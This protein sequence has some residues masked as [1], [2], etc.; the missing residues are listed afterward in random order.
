[1]QRNIYH[2]SPLKLAQFCLAHLRLNAE[3]MPENLLT[4]LA[5]V[6][7]FGVRVSYQFSDVFAS[8]TER[9]LS[10]IWC[11]VLNEIWT[12]TLTLQVTS[13]LASSS[14]QSYLP[15]PHSLFST[16]SLQRSHIRL[17]RRPIYLVSRHHDFSIPE[18]AQVYPI[19]V[20]CYLATIR[21]WDNLR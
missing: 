18:D 4:W 11:A 12:N 5:P 2:P 17:G 15:F 6:Q 7:V 21:T 8:F 16:T 20:L 10:S 19:R 3:S 9:T 13:K 1:M 14:S